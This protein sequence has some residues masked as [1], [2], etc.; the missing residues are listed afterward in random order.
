MALEP[1]II[2]LDPVT[3][4]YQDYSQE[5]SNL[6]A[7]LPLDTDFSGSTDYIEYYVYDQ[8]SNL[9]FPEVSTVPLNQYTIKEGDVLLDPSQNLRS[10]GYIEGDYIITYDFYRNRCASNLNSNYFIEVISSDRTEIQLSSNTTENGK[11][12]VDIDNS[13]LDTYE[14][15]DDNELKL[16]FTLSKMHDI[17]LYSKISKEIIIILT[18]NYPIKI[19][20]SVGENYGK[21]TFYLAPKF[22]EN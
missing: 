9:L 18:E 3:F 21:M 13:M 8:N 4:E 15:E 7:Q 10:L 5:D 19:I 20:Y 12:E 1:N 22:N 6:I 14:L 17:C 11:M 2:P 16:S